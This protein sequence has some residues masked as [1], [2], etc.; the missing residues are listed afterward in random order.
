VAVLPAVYDPAPVIVPPADGDAVAVRVYL[1]SWKVAVT[2]LLP[3]MVI[4][5]EDVLLVASPLQPTKVYPAAGVAVNV[6]V[7]PAVYDPAPVIVPPADGDAVAV[8]VYL[9]S[10]KV[11]VTV[12]LPSMVTVI[13]DVLPVAS[14]LQPTKVYPAA[15]VAVNVAVL[16]DVYDPAPVIVPPADGD[17]VAVRVY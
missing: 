17:A 8:R 10:W 1:I 16:P 12:L 15:G 6:A 5:M 14:S 11:A 9:I 13:E 7:L 4:L 3:S 2:V